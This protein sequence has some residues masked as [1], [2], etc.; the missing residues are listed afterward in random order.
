MSD[1]L[2]GLTHTALCAR[3]LRRCYTVI[4]TQN[5]SVRTGGYEA[6]SVQAL[7]YVLIAGNI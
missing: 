4:K 3:S 1:R 5:I 6:P 7:G 2:L